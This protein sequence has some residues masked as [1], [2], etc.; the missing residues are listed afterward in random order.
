M[1]NEIA[2]YRKHKNLKL[3]ASE[4][5]MPWQT[6][7]VHLKN[8]GEPV[9]GDKLRYGTDRDRLG[10]MAELEFKR[11]VPNAV[12]ANEFIHQA[13]YDFDVFDYKVD[14]KASRPRKLSKR[15]A[16]ESWSF[17]FKKQSLVCDFMV[18]FCL[19]H[20]KQ[21]E[22]VLLVPSEFFRGLQTVSVSR[23]G[24]SKWL[25]YSIDPNEMSAFFDALPRNKQ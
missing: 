16:A 25:D 9:T 6:L 15:Y 20:D 23:L 7:Y 24:G 12:N 4:L 11:L 21:I 1:Q 18:C 19:D 17:S 3:A 14:V 2:T 22:H 13:K 5:G 8:A 10:A